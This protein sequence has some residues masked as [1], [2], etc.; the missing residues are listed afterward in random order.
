MEFWPQ[1]TLSTL[2][3]PHQRCQYRVRGALLLMED[4][5]GLITLLGLLLVVDDDSLLTTS[6]HLPGPFSSIFLVLPF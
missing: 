1:I 4:L 2:S 3:A 5:E 6:T